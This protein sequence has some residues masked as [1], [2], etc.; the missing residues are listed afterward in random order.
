VATAEALAEIGVALSLDDFGTGYSSLVRLK[1]LPVTE[2]KVDSSFVGRLLES[3]DD[4]VV[5]K[6]I[7]DLAAALGIRSVAEGVES[8][9]VASALLAMGCVA[10]Q[11]WHL[12][13]PLNAASATAWLAEH[14][15]PAGHEPH[16]V[17]GHGAAAR[18]TAAL[19]PS[20]WRL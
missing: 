6:S 8:A 4:E 19:P 3:P 10:A 9:E 17:N 16:S 2:V 13:R 12:C 18:R 1:R 5:V 15:E 14:G 11:G 20:G 7:V